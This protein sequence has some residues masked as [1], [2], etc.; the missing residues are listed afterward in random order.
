MVDP[1]VVATSLC[2]IKS[3]MPVYCGFQSIGIRGRYEI[4][5][6]PVNGADVLDFAERKP[7]GGIDQRI[8]RDRRTQTPAHGPEPVQIVLMD[9]GHRHIG[10][11][12]L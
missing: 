3:L 11:N 4:E 7:A 12:L 1:E 8:R 9:Q 10:A 5:A 2:Q 6:G